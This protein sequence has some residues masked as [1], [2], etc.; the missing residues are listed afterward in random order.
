MKRF[1]ITLLIL[2][3]SVIAIKK[4]IWN[5]YVVLRDNPQTVFVKVSAHDWP[6]EIFWLDNGETLY[7]PFDGNVV[8]QPR[9]QIYVG[10]HDAYWVKVYKYGFHK[11]DVHDQWR[12]PIA[13][14]DYRLEVRDRDTDE[15][16]STVY[17]KA[18]LIE[19][20]PDLYQEPVELDSMGFL[21]SKQ[22]PC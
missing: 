8:S 9:P 2:A 16:I 3:A 20:E 6:V 22:K 21:F 11:D 5:S 13:T 1:L 12:F 4:V 14:G 7:L 17:I 18:Y 10:D 15:V 19:D